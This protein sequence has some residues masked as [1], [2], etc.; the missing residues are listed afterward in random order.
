MAERE[1]QRLTRSAS[2]SLFGIVSTARTSLW[3]ARDHLLCIDTTGYGETYKRFYFRDIQAI[4]LL[5]STR[6]LVWSAVLGALAVVCALIGAGTGEIISASV[7]GTI[8]GVF[9]LAVLTNL[10][11]GPSCAT[12]LRTAVQTELLV[13]VRRV[14]QARRVLAR[15][16]PLIAAAQ[17]EL[18]PDDLAARLRG[19]TD[20]PDPAGGQKPEEPSA[21][22]P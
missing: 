15:L 9:F 12:Y 21:S 6:W 17:G 14:R 10:G 18:T 2:R 20:A 13:S 5:R 7:F 11:A 22:E 3:L 19:G 4:T 8:A 1:Y 16:R